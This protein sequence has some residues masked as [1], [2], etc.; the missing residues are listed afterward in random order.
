M[1]N[2]DNPKYN[3][4]SPDF[5]RDAYREFLTKKHADYMA[6][7]PLVTW[8][9]SPYIP[10]TDILS[11]KY[12]VDADID[13]RTELADKNIAFND[14]LRRLSEQVKSITH[15]FDNLSNEQSE[16]NNVPAL[17]LESKV[18]PRDLAMQQGALMTIH[19]RLT[20]P[21]T[22]EFEHAFTSNAIKSLPGE[23]GTYTEDDS[24]QISLFPQ[25]TFEE[26]AKIHSAFLG[27]IF[28]LAYDSDDGDS[29]TLKFYAPSICRELGIDPRKYS[30]A[31]KNTD[32]SLSDLR[33]SALYDQIR[34]FERYVGCIDGSYYRLLIF[35]AYDS[36]SEVMT[37]KAPYIFQLFDKIIERAEIVQH[38]QLNRLIHS[39]VVNEP[40]YSA[41]E[42]ANCIIN[43]V[44]QRGGRSTVDKQYVYRIRYSNLISCCPQLCKELND[45]ANS[46]ERNHKA[47]T[48]NVKLKRTFEAAYRIIL[49]ESD[50]P[51]IFRDLKINGISSWASTYPSGKSKRRTAADFSIPTKSRLND[52]LTIT[53][54]GGNTISTD[55]GTS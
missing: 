23:D 4:A 38:S 37:V 3:P 53:H 34:P 45:I 29:Q 10:E 52:V 42:L 51:E 44:L 11:D 2:D 17:K 7:P 28:S 46:A 22:S 40:N 33:F 50:L 6:T 21:S 16:N 9:R 14:F 35:I 41:V 31:R 15:P 47:Q 48:Y 1:S 54:R 49:E 30:T 13:R 5:D 32:M 20:S 39:N 27:A 12:D 24:G 18:N 55:S 43:R 8:S 36:N 26:I 25:K 19:G